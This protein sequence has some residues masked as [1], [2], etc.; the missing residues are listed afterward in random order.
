VVS[1]NSVEGAAGGGAGDADAG[2]APREYPFGDPRG[3]ELDPVYA[4]LLREDPMPRVRLP[5]GDD[6]WLLTTYDD[7]QAGLTD[8][9]FSRAATLTHDLPRGDDL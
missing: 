4:R 1:T 5:Y 9:R 7:V 2:A 6:A 3:L 8:A